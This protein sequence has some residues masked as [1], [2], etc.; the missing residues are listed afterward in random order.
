METRIPTHAG[1]ILVLRTATSYTIHVVGR[2]TNDGQQDFTNQKDL[3]YE[4]DAAAAIAMANVSDCRDDGFSFWTSTPT[5]GPRS[6]TRTDRL[7]A[8]HSDE[9]SIRH[10]RRQTNERRNPEMAPKHRGQRDRRAGGTRDSVE[11]SDR[12][13]HATTTA[14]SPKCWRSPVQIAKRRIPVSPTGRSPAAAAGRV[15]S[16]HLQRAAPSQGDDVASGAV[17]FT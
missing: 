7:S 5:L 11:F 12:F 8:R 14:P 2:I 6:P 16:H 1:D 3:K 15:A 4:R 10:R 9:K 17:S 13:Q